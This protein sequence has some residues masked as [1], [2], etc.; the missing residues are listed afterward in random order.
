MCVCVCYTT[1]ALLGAAPSAAS[2]KGGPL[3]AQ[4]DGQSTA[5]GATGDK[6]WELSGDLL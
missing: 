6:D 2:E 4:A 3:Q 5:Q 1:S